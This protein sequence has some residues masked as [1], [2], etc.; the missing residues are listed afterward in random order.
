MPTNV[1]GPGRWRQ[2]GYEFSTNLGDVVKPFLKIEKERKKSK[3]REG[4]ERKVFL[5]TFLLLE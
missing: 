5:V 1:P 3:R 4:V 2:G